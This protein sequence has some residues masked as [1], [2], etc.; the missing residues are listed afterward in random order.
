M[1]M[2]HLNTLLL[3]LCCSI[4]A[5]CND[6][7][8]T[9][10]PIDTPDSPIVILYDNDVH[11]SVD[12]YSALVALRNE[13]LSTSQYV[14]TVS[15]GD[16]ASGGIVGAISKGEEIAEI[17]NYVGY[18]VVTLGNHEL[19]YG[20]EQMFKITDLLEAHVVCA[21][22]NNVQT[23]S[24]PYP[25][26]HIV[27]YGEVDVAYIG[28]TTTSSGTVTSLSDKQGA[29]LYSFMRD[30]FYDIAQRQIDEARKSGAD[31]VIALAHLGDSQS[32]AATP[33]SVSLINNTTGLDAVIDGHDH[34]TIATMTIYDR[35]GKGVVL[36]SSGSNFS[37]I[38]K[39]SIDTEGNIHTS[40]ID[41]AECNVDNDT[42]QFIEQIKAEI[43]ELGNFS[44]GRSEVDLMIYDADG[45]R[46]VRKEE[47]NLGDFCADAFRSFTNADIALVNGG[48][49]RSNLMRGEILFN[50]LYNVMPFGDMVATGRLTGAQIVDVL[51]YSVSALPKEAGSFMQVSGLQ[52][53]VDPNIASNVVID[54]ESMLYSHIEEGERRVSNVKILDR[55]SNEY[56]DVELSRDYTIATLDY[57]I[58]EKGNNGILDC[59]TPDPTYWGAD[60]EI[61]RH[62][63][64]TTLNGCI[65]EEYS[66]PQG[67]II[68]R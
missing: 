18:D 42:Q 23:N 26:Y 20:I 37:H 28:F 61:L 51:E 52:F 66:Q 67:R 10:N 45:N 60:I 65:G 48:G 27:K 7:T 40:L 13:Q 8:T 30:E 22:L 57:L 44:I 46:T 58:L 62:Y 31:Y 53:E 17:M 19:D 55:V 6:K 41:I 11:C 68:F 5:A 56:R 29:P 24:F 39:L 9:S 36:T 49:I 32:A 63:L 54:S 15:C 4:F 59:V 16:F 47:S 35:S 34:H 2:R 25:A 43:G 14:A 38:G 64:E 50:D 33:N 3:S 21:N 1:K 12:G